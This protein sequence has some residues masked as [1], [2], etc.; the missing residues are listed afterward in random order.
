M[1]R[2]TE[3]GLSLSEITGQES[4]IIIYRESG[5]AA[6][7]NW[8]SL[9]GLPRWLGPLPQPISLGADV[10]AL[11]PSRWRNLPVHLRELARLA[12]RHAEQE[13]PGNPHHIGPNPGV[14]VSEQIAVIVPRG[15]N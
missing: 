13:Q 3:P 8:T 14:W 4:G 10:P 9:Q 15:W 11:T 5:E 1:T 6:V 2:H 7:L 12:C